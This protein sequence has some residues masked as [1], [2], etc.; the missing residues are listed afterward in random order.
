MRKEYKYP[1]KICK[2]CK[3]NW[4]SMDDADSVAGNIF[5][6]HCYMKDSYDPDCKHWD[7]PPCQ[8]GCYAT[9]IETYEES[10]SEV[11]WENILSDDEVF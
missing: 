4:L 3:Y 6:T 2:D 9:N 1:Q 8:P 10:V 7:E 11:S 5:D